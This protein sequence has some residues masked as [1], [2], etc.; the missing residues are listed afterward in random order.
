MPR[1]ILSNS[2]KIKIFEFF[3]K[4][5][6]IND[7]RLLAQKFKVSIER[8]KAI[9]KQK[10]LELELANQGK[11]V[12]KEFVSALESNLECVEISDENIEFREHDK[13]LPFRPLFSCIQEGSPFTFEDAKK[14]LTSTGI[15]II[16]PS[17]ETNINSDRINIRNVRIPT[18]ISKSEFETSR[19]KFIFVNIKKKGPQN[20]CNVLVRDC[21]GTLREATFKESEYASGKTWNRNRPKVI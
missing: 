9:I 21:D 16:A 7:H 6:N 2:S 20:G 1:S 15:N 3:K 14:A 5:P 4:N 11:I 10:E 8:V 17:L 13:K 18:T 19:S 12:D